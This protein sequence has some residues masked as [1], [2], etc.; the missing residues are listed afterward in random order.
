MTLV[1][2]SSIIR[3]LLSPKSDGPIVPQ[4]AA[5]AK[6]KSSADFAVSPFAASRPARRPGETL[7]LV[8]ITA[9]GLA[10]VLVALFRA[11]P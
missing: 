9:A 3:G 11:V 10:A 2:A 4:D 6:A 1:S 7:L 8:V 5:P